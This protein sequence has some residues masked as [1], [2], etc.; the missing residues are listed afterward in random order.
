VRKYTRKRRTNKPQA[1]VE[2]AG[3]LHVRGMSNR[4]IGRTLGVKPHT[5]P[6][7]L[8]ESEVVKRHLARLLE[9]V[10]QTLESFKLLTSPHPGLSVEELGR[11]VRWAL[12]YTG[13]ATKR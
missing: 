8:A 3:E 11:N 1:L 10:S 9:E 7:M 12:E 6:S 4:Q 13:V 2:K 5:V